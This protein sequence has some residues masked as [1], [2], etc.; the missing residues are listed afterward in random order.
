[1]TGSRT[2]T[3]DGLVGAYCAGY[4]PMGDNRG[5][6]PIRWHNPDPRA[7]LPLT[8][9]EGLHVPRRLWERLRASPYEMTTDRAF[10]EVMRRC[11]AP[12]PPPG[13]QES[14]IDERIIGAYTEL[15]RAGHAHSIEAWS[16]TEP[17][18]LVGGLYGVHIGAAFFAESK[19]YTPRRGTDA[20][21]ICLVH[22][23]GHLR[24]R[25]FEL[26]DVQFWNPHLAQ[27]GCMDI[28]RAEYLERLKVATTKPVAWL[29]FN[30]TTVGIRPR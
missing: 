23:V 18:E 5:P 22:L 4:F 12:R 30:P 6:E 3:V 16:R 2:N 7:I 19:F 28:P 11:A 14:W 25:G 1:M 20:S 26:L 24:E 15:H 9:E 27:F 29:P 17:S 13:E 10:E 8:P 21:K